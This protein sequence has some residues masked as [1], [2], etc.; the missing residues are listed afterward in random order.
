L[1]QSSHHPSNYQ[2]DILL[3]GHWRFLSQSP[4]VI[5]VVIIMDNDGVSVIYTADKLGQP[6]WIKFPVILD[7]GTNTFEFF[8]GVITKY[9]QY[10]P[11]G[12]IHKPIEHQHWISFG[13]S[14]DGY[15]NLTEMEDTGYLSWKQED[16]DAAIKALRSN[17]K[18]KKAAPQNTA[19]GTGSGPSG[20][21][22]TPDQRNN[23]RRA[24]SAASKRHVKVKLEFGSNRSNYYDPESIEINKEEF[25]QW[26]KLIHRGVK[27][28]PISQSNYR[29]VMNRAND[30]IS[31]SGVSYKNWPADILFHEGQTVTLET[32]FDDLLQ[33]AKDHEKQYGEDKGHGWVLRH[34]IKKLKLFKEYVEQ[35]RHEQANPEM[36]D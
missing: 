8:K 16:A 34:P 27:G 9:E 29:C 28:D 12:D 4:I 3:N 25:S 22:V 2:R 13:D 35:K 17:N 10:F 18:K 20:A 7:D 30:L 21:V 14:D 19:G 23:K 36:I 15:F 26:L 33:K 1:K 11:D 24:E 32:D 31:G 5:V 6:V